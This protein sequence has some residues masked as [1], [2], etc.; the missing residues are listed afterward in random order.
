M[1]ALN[2]I[3]MQFGGKYLFKDVSLRFGDRERIAIVGPNG[4]GKTTL[5]KII[6]GMIESESGTITQSR[7]NTVGYL[8]QDGV[9]N[10]G[11]TLYEE[12]ATAFN[13]L[14]L[15]HDRIDEISSEIS[16]LTTNGE[17]NSEEIK[18]LLEEFGDLQQHIEHKEGYS[19]ET[20]V[21]QVLSGLGFRERDFNRVTDEF[22]GGWQM[23]IELAKLLL[24]EP[25]ILLL[26]E[27]TNHLDIESLEWLEDYLMSYEGT[28]VIISHDSRFL[29]NMV[30][31]IIE[32][33]LGKVIN[34]SGNYSFYLNAKEERQ[35]QLE[36]EY[37]NQ[38]GKIKQTRRF[39]ER[40]RYKATKARQVQS[41]IKMLEKI[42]RVELENHDKEIHFDFPPPPPSGRIVMELN[43]ISKVYG[44]IEV[45]HLLDYTIQRGDRIA[46]LGANGAGKSTLARIIAGIEPLTDG[47]RKEGHN[48]NI[49][50][51][52]QHQAEELDPGKTVYQTLD[53]IAGGDV[54]KHLRTLLGC[55]LFSGDDVFKSVRVLSGGE[56]SRL[57]LAKMLLTP[58][59]L[60]IFDEPTNH[61]DIRS[62]AVLQDALQNFEGT[63]IVVSHDRDF[64][65]ALINKV[66]EFKNGG[67]REFVG[68]VD[69]YLLK[70]HE[71]VSSALGQKEQPSGGDKISDSKYDKEHK[72]IEAEQRQERYR[73]LK[74]LKVALSK[75]E[76]QISV[77]EK[78]KG[79]IELALTDGE[80]YKDGEKAKQLNA[81]YKSTTT[82]LAHLYDEWTKVQEQMEEVGGE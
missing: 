35:N 17:S 45:F 66:V 59:N 75:I 34:Y 73:K 21:K 6:V 40:F 67:L 47:E 3:S 71:E 63:Y 12:A 76:N 19:I 2:N 56:R 70:K 62:K 36:A 61:L 77:E 81:E 10:V 32:I 16:K 33:S 64:L 18:S 60:L 50:Y 15:L 1:I 52:A 80:T 7:S 42:D 74:P 25:T 68:S 30:N 8:P 9:H 37:A 53:D 22:S 46:F 38:Q 79:E 5:M 72:R 57:A 31:R 24:R 82:N 26:D 48:V 28:V 41:R 13:D 44:D 65:E 54:R 78:K 4:S 23:R 51:Y 14:L 27:P 20:R 29:D 58:A 11:K 39:I 43:K 55:F 49:S 69:D